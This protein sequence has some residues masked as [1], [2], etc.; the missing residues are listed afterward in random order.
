VPPRRPPTVRRRTHR[1]A[2]PEAIGAVGGI[3]G[4]DRV[5]GRQR[6]GRP[7]DELLEPVGVEL[8]G[9][10][11]EPIAVPDRLDAVASGPQRAPQ[12]V[13]VRA[14]VVLGPVGLAPVGP[15]GVH[16]RRHVDHVAPASMRTASER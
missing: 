7:A 13:D 5:A 3:E 12:P 9:V 4:A 14:H 6:G 2:A 16:E 8:I 10:E 15:A 11:S 1:R